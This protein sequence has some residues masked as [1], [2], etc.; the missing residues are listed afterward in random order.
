MEEALREA[1]FQ[2]TQIANFRNGFAELYCTSG[3]RLSGD[4]WILDWGLVELL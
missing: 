1:R 4:G 3:L 2:A